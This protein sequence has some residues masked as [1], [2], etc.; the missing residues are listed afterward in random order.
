MYNRTDI[1]Q[2]IL[3]TYITNYNGDNMFSLSS[4][5]EYK[6]LNTEGQ[7]IFDNFI[8]VYRGVCNKDFSLKPSIGVNTDFLT[9][10]E[11]LIRERKALDEF[12]ARAK[13]TLGKYKF[14]MDDDSFYLYHARHV[15]MKCRLIDWSRRFEIAM[16]FA[17]HNNKGTD[18]AIYVLLVPS[19][20]YLPKFGTGIYE[21]D[22][23]SFYR[24]CSYWPDG[25]FAPLSDARKNMQHGCFTIQ[26][27]CHELT[28]SD[29]ESVGIGLSKI[30]VP[31]FLIPEIRDNG[32][33]DLIYQNCINPEYV[34][35]NDTLEA[36]ANDINKKYFEK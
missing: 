23:L 14:R 15:G 12:K 36:I 17:L 26:P 19:E 2:S 11:K 10:D 34:Q 18:A 33:T 27:H 32:E 4:Y 9:E 28:N 29:F 13:E 8:L 3:S 24:S 21:L 25:D 16:S 1:L 22:K 6:R 30:I 5:S 31:S 20:L 35:Q 7:R